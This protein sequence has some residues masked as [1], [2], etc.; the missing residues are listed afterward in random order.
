MPRVD[1][2]PKSRAELWQGLRQGLLAGAALLTL[3]LP[4]GLGG[5]TGPHGA[6]GREPGPEVA[7]AVTERHLDFGDVQPSADARQ[8]A[9]WI[10]ATAD[11]GIHPFAI[12]DKAQARVYLFRPSGRLIAASPV[13]LGYARGDDSVA[14]IG[15]R[16][17]AQVRPGERTTP[18]GRHLAHPG[19][20][21]LDDDVLW[22]DYDAAV[23]MHR[24][25]ATEP[26][27]QRLARLASPSPRDNRISYGC[28]NLPASFF[29]DHF[30]P[31]FGRGPSV[32]YVLPETKPLLAVFPALATR[33]A[34]A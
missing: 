29:D 12:V 13:L 27:E 34:G 19:R 17:I 10:V 9:G 14:G 1:I 21:A 18:A 31:H 33:M 5:A 26:R 25:R 20:N 32:V 24:V 22:V 4:P 6:G 7:S 3:V 23:S 2:D 8:L 11:N 15:A 30:W 16:P 28:I